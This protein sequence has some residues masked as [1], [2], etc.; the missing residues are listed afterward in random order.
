MLERLSTRDN[1]RTELYMNTTVGQAAALPRLAG[2]RHI[3]D[4]GDCQDHG[5]FLPKQNAGKFRSVCNCG[6]EVV[7][8]S[9]KDLLDRLNST[10]ADQ[11]VL[12]TS[13]N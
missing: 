1:N 10:S 13:V 7:D 5:Y 11:Q 9:D 12:L 3:I 6:V 2:F 4:D 8:V